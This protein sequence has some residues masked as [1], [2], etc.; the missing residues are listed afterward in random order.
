MHDIMISVQ[1][2][3]QA[4]VNSRN[5]LFYFLIKNVGEYCSDLYKKDK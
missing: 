2:L 4:N 5:L 3:S 1:Q